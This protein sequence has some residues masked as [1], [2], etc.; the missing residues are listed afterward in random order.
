M[1]MMSDGL[2]VVLA[3]CQS[4]KMSDWQDGRMSDGEDVRLAMCK[5]GKKLVGQMSNGQDVKWAICQ[6]GRV[7]EW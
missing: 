1:V 7:L 3:R 2:G 6:M 4:G 5:I